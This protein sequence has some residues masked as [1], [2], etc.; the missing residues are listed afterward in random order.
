MVGAL[1]NLN[2]H[3]TSPRTFQRLF[4]LLGL[5]QLA[6]VNLPTKLEVSTTAHH[7]D[8]KG[9]AKHKRRVV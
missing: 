7:K 9:D 3:M 6:T 1:Q 8:I 5:K 2:G 4:V